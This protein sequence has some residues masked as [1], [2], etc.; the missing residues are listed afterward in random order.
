MNTIRVLVICVAVVAT[1]MTTELVYQ[2]RIIVEAQARLSSW[3]AGGSSLFPEQFAL[4]E[5]FCRQHCARGVSKIEVAEAEWKHVQFRVWNTDQKACLVAV[6]KREGV[7]T[8]Q[9][10]PMQ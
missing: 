6:Y 5:Q 8:A 10:V 7:W 2:R 4:Q 9:A 3:I 1:G